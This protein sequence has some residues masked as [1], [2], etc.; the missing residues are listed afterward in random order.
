MCDIFLYAN[1][2]NKPIY[3]HHHKLI[4][5]YPTLSQP[6][7]P[8]AWGIPWGPIVKIVKGFLSMAT[9]VFRKH[10]LYLTIDADLRTMLKR[11]V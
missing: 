1:K 4:P 8:H 11:H 3:T 2:A 5:R 6:F 7:I 10:V 9:S